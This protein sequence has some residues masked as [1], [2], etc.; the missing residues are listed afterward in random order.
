MKKVCLYIT[1]SA[2]V[3]LAG[4]VA[5]GTYSGGNGTAGEP[6]LISTAADM[7]E[8]GTHPED[9]NDHFLLINDI[10]L[11]EYTGTEFNIIGDDVNAFTGVF[12]GNN[13][14]I[15]N[16]TYNSTEQSM[17]GIFGYVVDAVIK[18]T[19]IINPNI[20]I[21]GRSDY[22]GGL[23]GCFY[24]GSIIS[25]SVKNGFIS[26]DFRVGGLVGENDGLIVNCH[27]EVN[28]HG[29]G[30]VG[31]LV[32]RNVGGQIKQ[33]Y[34]ISDVNGSGGLGGLIGLNS[35]GQIDRCY[36]ISNV[37]GFHDVGGFSGFNDGPTPPANKI[38]LT[39]FL[40]FGKT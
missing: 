39:C 21:S 11:A 23:A 2:L 28:V 27:T 16:F 12:D 36:S 3:G 8:I 20:I 9:F 34:S 10:N 14:S 4:I 29:G 22:I 25:C 26:G 30:V 35:E 33:C 24:T 40:I 17:I 18:D 6:F 15:L 7:N 37:N 19:E 13:H 32:G 38:E 1:I 5:A 31:G